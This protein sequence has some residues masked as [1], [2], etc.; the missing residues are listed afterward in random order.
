MKKSPNK[1]FTFCVQDTILSVKQIIMGSPKIDV[2][3]TA[4]LAMKESGLT[5]FGG[6]DSSKVIERYAIARKLGM[7]K[8]KGKYTAIGKV[9]AKRSLLMVMKKKLVAFDYI[10]RHPSIENIRLNKPVF[11]IGFPRTGTTFLHELLSLHQNT[12]SFRTWEANLV[13]PKTDDESID[14]LMLD[15]QKRYKENKQVAEK[16]L[17]LMRSETHKRIHR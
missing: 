3:S 1:S 4:K 6:K 5:D 16:M 9:L 8:S 11:V 13:T 15:R 2:E 12:R 14:V 17:S 10:K 7:D